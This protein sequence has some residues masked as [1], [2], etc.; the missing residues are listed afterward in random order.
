MSK[1]VKQNG[2]LQNKIIEMASHFSV[3]NNN[4]HNTNTTN[5]EIGRAHV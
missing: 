2:E 5:I 3:T 1:C 4:S